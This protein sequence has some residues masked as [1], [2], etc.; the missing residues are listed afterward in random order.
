MD[1]I[2]RAQGLLEL[3]TKP[4]SVQKL[5][6]AGMPG[7]ADLVLFA[8]ALMWGINIIVFKYATNGYD[9]WVFNGLRLIFATLTLGVLAWAEAIFS[10]RSVSKRVPWLRVIAFCFISGALYLIIFVKGIALTT[11]GNTALILASMPMWTALLSMHFLQERLPPVTWLGLLVTFF[12]TLI[13][14][15]QGSGNVSLASE[16]FVG[17]LFML[18]AA[19]VWASGTVLSKGI[20]EAISPLRL[21]FISALLTTPVHLVIAYFVATTTM[22]NFWQETMRPMTVVAIVYS[23]IFS[24]GVAYATWHFGVRAVGGSHAAVY[25]NV[26]TLV[27]VFGGWLL[28]GETLVAVQLL[29]GILTIVGLLLMRRGRAG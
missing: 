9:P 2:R 16:Y 10:P 18:V 26:V 13:V 21:A 27:A 23:G 6:T 19:I 5:A 17:N 29:G 4:K 3:E 15:T 8:T 11:A 1:D 24:T 14:T 28:L 12:G 22:P 25:Q 7:L 20:L